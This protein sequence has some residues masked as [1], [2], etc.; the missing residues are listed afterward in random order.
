MA[1]KVSVVALAMC[2][3][4][5]ADDCKR[6]LGW[7]YFSGL[8]AHVARCVAAT[9]GKGVSA[10]WRTTFYVYLTLSEDRAVGSRRCAP[11]DHGH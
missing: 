7:Q 5:F 6:N 11:L 9:V 3:R 4:S 8:E 2:F 10:I 1:H